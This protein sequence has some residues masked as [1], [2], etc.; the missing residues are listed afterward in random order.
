MSERNEENPF[1]GER[2]TER[3]ETDLRARLESYLW[4]DVA[5]EVARRIELLRTSGS[6]EGAK[7]AKRMEKLLAKLEEL[8]E[9]FDR[10]IEEMDKRYYELTQ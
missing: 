9:E 5:H 8:D 4:R 7:A 1:E 6:R 10:A 2:I 3:I